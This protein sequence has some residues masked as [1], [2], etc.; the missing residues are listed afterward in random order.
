MLQP[1]SITVSIREA[2]H[3]KHTQP[4]TLTMIAR[5]VISDPCVQPL[6]NPMR[7]PCSIKYCSPTRLMDTNPNVTIVNSEPT[8]KSDCNNNKIDYY[9]A[10]RHIFKCSPDD[11]PPTCNKPRLFGCLNQM[12]TDCMHL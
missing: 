6:D 9:L 3:C 4:R 1:I 7:L 5:N 11:R 2:M 10:V 8:N 12:R